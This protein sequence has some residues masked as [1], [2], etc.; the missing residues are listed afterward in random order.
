MIDVERR[1][2]TPPSL[3]SGDSWSGRDV[4]EALHADFAGKCYLC[5]RQH[6]FP[7]FEVDHRI[8][9]NHYPHPLHACTWANLFPAC[10]PCNKRRK[11]SW[12]D[13]G[14]VSPG[15]FQDLEARM[16]QRLDYAEDDQVEPVFAAVGVEDTAARNTA[17]EL[18]HLHST[19]PSGQT[20]RAAQKGLDLCSAIQTR[21]IA[22]L[23]LA[24]AYERHL[25]ESPDS[26]ACAITRDKLAARLSRRKPFTALLRSRF[27]D[28]PHIVALF[29]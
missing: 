29:D 13:G 20:W 21:L 28:D 24:R 25:R 22:V 23:E 2:E 9:R 27:V 16:I 8:P 12:P 7:V 26:A 4:I 14:M 15:W 19:T 17:A 3:A 10:E 1:T 18:R 5:E 11:R 6:A